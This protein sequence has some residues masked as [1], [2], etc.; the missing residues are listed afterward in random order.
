MENP[1]NLYLTYK[2]VSQRERR[3]T[4]QKLNLAE[5]ATKF[6][7]VI[8]EKQTLR[9]VEE[10]RTAEKKWL[11]VSSGSSRSIADEFERALRSKNFV[12]ERP[13]LSTFYASWDPDTGV[14]YAAN[15]PEAPGI[16]K[17]GATKGAI[18]SLSSRLDT[19]AT[20]YKI[21]RLEIIHAR[22]VDYPS[23]IENALHQHLSQFRVPVPWNKSN[24]W[25]SL[26][27]RDA[28]RAINK[29]AKDLPHK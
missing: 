10:F 9:S 3:C 16:I 21:Q 15:F 22:E 28:I 27:K 19:Y 18:S 29:F 14:V 25:Y 4:G 26:T 24:E 2:K 17:I 7:R 8:L 13:A 23:R 12:I 5:I 6:A 1:T 11:E 20:R